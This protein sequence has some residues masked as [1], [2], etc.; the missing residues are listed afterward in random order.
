MLEPEINPS[1]I[2]EPDMNKCKTKKMVEGRDKGVDPV[3]KLLGRCRRRWGG[4]RGKI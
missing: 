2:G 4:E 1:R 3:Q